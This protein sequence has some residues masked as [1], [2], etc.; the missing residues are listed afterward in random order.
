MNKIQYMAVTLD[1]LE[2]PVAVANSLTELSKMVHE[3]PLDIFVKINHAEN[4][5]TNNGYVRC[6]I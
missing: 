4:T 3:K 1:E 6:E 5:G 2:L